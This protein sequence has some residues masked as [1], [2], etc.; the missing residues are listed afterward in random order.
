MNK[1]EKL[2]SSVNS[3]MIAIELL[4]RIQGTEIYKLEKDFYKWSEQEYEDM[5]ENL[6]GI[7]LTLKKALDKEDLK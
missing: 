6:G 5:L 4:D 2:K 1:K 7:Y 3:M